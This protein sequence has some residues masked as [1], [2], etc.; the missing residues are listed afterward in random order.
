MSIGRFAMQL[1]TMSHLT[2]NLSPDAAELVLFGNAE[3]TSGT[4][5]DLGRSN[6]QGMVTSTA[7]V[8]FAQTLPM[9]FLVP[10]AEQHVSVGVTVKYTVGNALILGRNVGSVVSATTGDIDLAFPIIQ[11][12]SIARMS[13]I[14]RG[15]GVG[16]DVGAA[17]RAGRLSVSASVRNLYNTF[18]WDTAGFVYRAGQVQFDGTSGDAQFEMEAYANAP[19]ELRDAVREFTFARQIVVGGAFRRSDRFLVS[20]DL[21]QHVGAGITNGP[22]S[23]VGVAMELR[24]LSF[25]PLRTGYAQITGGYQLGAGAGLDLGP[26]SISASVGRRRGGFGSDDMA[27]FGLTFGD[28]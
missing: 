1:S 4:D 28:R 9:R 3:R 16:I 6:V 14:D 20:A 26:V 25:L 17:W 8:S 18:A 22:R 21:R 23:H 5:F 7:A 27:A 15:R 12:D 24:P 19:A 2:A 10:V 11:S 13:A